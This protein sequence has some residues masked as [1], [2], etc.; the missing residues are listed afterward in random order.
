MT[1]STGKWEMT[2]DWVS[3]RAIVDRVPVHVHDLLDA[4]DEF[5]ASHEMALLEGQRSI[6][7]VPL[8]R[9]GEAIGAIAIR[10]LE[11]QPFTQKQIELLTIFAD[12]AVI[13]IENVR[14]F[15]EVAGPHPR[16]Q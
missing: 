1:I 13:A 14:L 5:P 11:V 16:S 2:R 4:A 12:Q 6:V 9:E 8:L 7:A 15:E 3:S 10:R